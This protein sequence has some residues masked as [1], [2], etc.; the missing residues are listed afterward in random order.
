MMRIIFVNIAALCLSLFLL[1]TASQNKFTNTYSDQVYKLRIF[2]TVDKCTNILDSS[3]LQ[4]ICVEIS[5]I[6]GNMIILTSGSQEYSM[7]I[8]N[9]TFSVLPCCD[10]YSKYTSTGIQ[11]L[12][13]TDAFSK[14]N[15]IVTINFSY[16]FMPW[17]L[18]ENIDINKIIEP[19]DTNLY[20]KNAPLAD[21]NWA[22]SKGL[23]KGIILKFKQ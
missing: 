18:F 22:K 11:V 10:P 9:D 21:S 20:D 13:L 23:E 17:A 7:G 2:R 4:F 19:L 3:N 15:G 12:F 16:G 1:S 14:F 6:D 8:Y 5:R